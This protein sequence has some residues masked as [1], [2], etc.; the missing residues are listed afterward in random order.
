MEE[1]PTFADILF[2]KENPNRRLSCMFPKA[3]TTFHSS[4]VTRRR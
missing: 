4:I 2:E 1:R 3:P